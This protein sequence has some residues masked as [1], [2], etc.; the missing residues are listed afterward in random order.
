MRSALKLP[1]AL[2][3]QRI[4]LFGGSFDPPHAGH[5][6]VSL[7]ALR[8]L[9]LDQV[10]WLVTPGNPLK[11]REPG[12]LG[13]RIAAARAIVAGHPGIRI[14]A[15]EATLGTRYTADTLS[16]LSQRLAGV[17][18]VWIMGADNLRQF[19]RWRDWRRIAGLM[20]IAVYDRP[21][22]TFRGPAAPAAVALARW[23]IDEQDAT[24]LPDLEAPAWTFL[25]GPR[26]ALSSTA[27]RAARHKENVPS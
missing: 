15:V 22:S 7:M 26:V 14:T 10:W 11:H 25:H 8:R 19:H 16:L 9:Q 1:L 18:L 21:G 13:R 17:K 5:V 12:D 23:R 6:M 27:L 3:G 20:P 4:G 24:L 2:P